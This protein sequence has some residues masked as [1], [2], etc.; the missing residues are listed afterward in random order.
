MLRVDYSTLN[1]LKVG[2]VCL[3]AEVCVDGFCQPDHQLL[4]LLSLDVHL[5][6]VDEHNYKHALLLGVVFKFWQGLQ[7]RNKQVVDVLSEVLLQVSVLR[8]DEVKD[9]V[10]TC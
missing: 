3:V 4:D 9:P 1:L 2:L 6:S 8:E 10:L 5:S 7:D